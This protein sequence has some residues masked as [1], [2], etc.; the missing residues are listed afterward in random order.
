MFTVCFVMHAACP[1]HVH[2]L[3]LSLVL[4][5]I[6]YWACV[7]WPCSLPVPDHVR[8]LFF[9]MWIEFIEMFAFDLSSSKL[10]KGGP[11]SYSTYMQY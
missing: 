2:R 3:C 1:C 8:H 9:V 4:F 10:P 6:G 7:L 5:P 11:T